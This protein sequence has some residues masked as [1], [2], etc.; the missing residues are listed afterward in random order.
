MIAKGDTREEARTRLLDALG[1]CRL[2]GVETNREFLRAALAAPAFVSGD[3]STRLLDHVSVP[4]QAIEV[5]DGGTQTTVQDHP[6]RLGYW[7]VGVPPSGPMDALSFRLANRLVGN[8]ATAAGLECTLTGPTLRFRSAAVVALTGADMG[9]T[10]NGAPL[11]AVDRRSVSA[12]GVIELGPVRGTGS[13]A[14][15]AVRGGFDVPAYLGS[16][17]TFT[18]GP[19]GGHSGRALQTGDVLHVGEQPPAGAAAVMSS[20]LIPHL[21]E[22]GRSRCCRPARRAGLLHRGRH[23][24]AVLGGVEGPLQLRAAPA[25]G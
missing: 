7:H 15:L 1:R 13:R 23:A 12:G 18:L 4:S 21:T 17:A 16:R 11:D 20:A 5:L 24:D 25:C 2:A 19:F 10:L 3:V 6:G 22:S 14:Y 8:P 9:A